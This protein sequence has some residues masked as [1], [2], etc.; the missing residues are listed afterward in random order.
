MVFNCIEK[1][2]DPNENEIAF[3]VYPY[4]EYLFN[5]AKLVR[6]GGRHLNAC[7]SG[8]IRGAVARKVPVSVESLNFNSSFSTAAKS[9]SA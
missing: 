9:A 1:D 7:Y 8:L 2:L 6:Q 5:G 4:G 3:K